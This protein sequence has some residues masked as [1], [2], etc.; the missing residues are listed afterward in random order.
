MP[1][2]T[3]GG[4]GREYHTMQVHYLGVDFTFADDGLAL[5]MGFLPVGAT[6]IR[7]GVVVSTAFD[8]GSTNVLDIGTGADPDGLASDMALGTAGVITAGSELATSD[9][10]GPYAVDTEIFATVDLTGTA[11][12]AGV[13]RAW[14]EYLVPDR[15]A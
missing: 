13:A 4:T 10:V 14:V 2:N 12:T 15:V 6:V 11:A 1:T 3:A 8:A 7:R 5:S 9:D